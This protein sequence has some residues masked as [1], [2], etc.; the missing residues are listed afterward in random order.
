MREKSQ[1]PGNESKLKQRVANIASAASSKLFE[2]MDAA[3][4]FYVGNRSSQGTDRACK[5][6]DKEIKAALEQSAEAQAHA[7]TLDLAFRGLSEDVV[8]GHEDGRIHERVIGVADDDSCYIL[9]RYLKDDELG[10]E[11]SLSLNDG[12]PEQLPG[13]YDKPIYNL[14]VMKPRQLGTQGRFDREVTT[15]A[16]WPDSPEAISTVSKTRVHDRLLRDI[17]DDPTAL[18]S[19][20]CSGE[21][22][23][24][25]QISPTDYETINDQVNLAMAAFLR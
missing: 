9:D 15:I 16:F 20:S 22:K 11:S 7:K 19:A 14:H 25:V 8:V 24:A 6:L 10:F 5:N 13:L 4:E 18:L 21:Y 2:V 3:G 17:Y 23:M 1:N 12:I